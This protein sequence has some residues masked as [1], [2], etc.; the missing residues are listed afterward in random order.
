MTFEFD[1]TPIFD[2]TTCGQLTVS[3][4]SEITAQAF[5]VDLEAV[6]DEYLGEL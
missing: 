3:D 4:F 2:L 5:D 6:L 1:S